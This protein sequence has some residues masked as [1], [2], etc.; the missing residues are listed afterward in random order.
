M[1]ES[2]F[3]QDV[4][5]LITVQSGLPSTNPTTPTWQTPPHPTIANAMS[6]ALP[7]E[8]DI[9]I[10]GSG[11]T[12]IGAA[13][14]LLR[15]PKG[16]G[17]KVTMLE[18]RTAVS[19]ATGRNGGHLVS[20]S[21]S[22]FPALAET[23]GV[24]RAIETVRFSDANIRRLKDLIAQLDPKDR[25]AVEF[26]EVT[27][28][29]SYADQSSFRGAIE[30]V[31]QLLEAVPDSEIKFKV[32]N[33]EEAAKIFN[34]T[35]VVGAVAQT[36]VAALWPYRLLTAVLASLRKE[37]SDRFS[38]ETNTPVLSVQVQDDT[39]EYPY[40]VRTSRGSIR[41]K[42]VIHCTNGYSSHLIPGLVGNLYSLRGTM[43]TQKLGPKFP[44]AGHNISWSQVSLGTYDAKTG[45]IHIGL[46]YA[47]QN[48]K[49][50]VMFLGG[51]SQSLG[52]LLTSDDSN[53]AEDAR[54]TLTSA[55]PK[56][57]KDAAPAEALNVWSGIMGFTADGMPIVG[58]LPQKLTGRSGSGEWIAA[59]FNGHGM[60]KCWLTGEA[61]ARMVLG[62]ADVPGFPKAYLLS[63]GRMKSWSP[64]GA[65]ETLMD[66]IIVGS[67]VP[68]SHL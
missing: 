46:Y 56:I 27:S 40:L 21:D 20:D 36:G 28:A 6:H 51:E 14:S 39:S 44:R 58:K 53:V 48:A 29:T 64:Q 15:H 52:G 54:Q 9:I 41:A 23:I 12:G 8:T 3:I 49:T 24:E 19:G 26:R 63:D 65:A 67:Q 17:L 4:V 35:N 68:N 32:Y 55:A 59:G 13:H 60:D 2:K 7:S 62:E 37:F 1:T 45:H 50:G 38:L 61:I 33:S 57:W 16:T 5:K 31:K 66:H 30:E 18:A 22:L 25:E 42:H 43:S 10:I 47:Q 34:F 11:I